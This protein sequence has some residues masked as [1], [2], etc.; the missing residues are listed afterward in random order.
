MKNSMFIFVII[1]IFALQE[2]NAQ[3]GKGSYLVSALGSANLEV[4]EDEDNLFRISIASEVAKFLTNKFALGGGIGITY[5][6]LDSQNNRFVSNISSNVRYYFT[7]FKKNPAFYL[8]GQVGL[9][10]INEKI[11]SLT[12]REGGLLYSIGLGASHFITENICVDSLLTYSR[13]EGGINIS[14]F[15]FN[16][17]FLV[18]LRKKEQEM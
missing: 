2:S 7:G 8:R 9:A 16:I 1:L 18:F 17:G 3:V 15:R 10:M 14:N 5:Q 12:E 4:R 13:V 11:N 6:D